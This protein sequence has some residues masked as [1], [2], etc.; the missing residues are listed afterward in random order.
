[1]FSQFDKTNTHG[2]M[3]R[4]FSWLCTCN[5]M[6]SG[7]IKLVLSLSLSEMIKVMQVVKKFKSDLE[8]IK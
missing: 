1:M 5:S 8:I 3:G 7:G 4:S 6:K 2:R